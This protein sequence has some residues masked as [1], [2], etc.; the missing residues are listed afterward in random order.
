MSWQKRA[1]PSRPQ[2]VDVL[3]HLRESLQ[4]QWRR[5]RKRL[6]RCQQHFSEDAVHASRVETRRLLSILELIGAFVPESDLRKVRRDLK[7]HL[8]TFDQ[9]RD[10]QVQL[11]YV[12]RMA[13]SFPDAWPF[14]EWLRERKVRFTRKT[15][16]AVK[17]IKIRR[18]G[19]HRAAL[20]REIRRQ[21]KQITREQAF[22]VVERAIHQAF[23]QVAQ[24]CR[25]VRATDTRTIH[26]TRIAF[27]RFRYMVEA[28]AP[29]LPAVTQEHH[30]AMRGYQCMM[31]D[32]QDMEVLLAALDK[33]VQ[34][35]AVDLASA[36]RLKRELARWRE[37]LIQV[38][39]NAADR[40]QRFWPPPDPGSKNGPKES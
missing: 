23:A 13:G 27:K 3:Q 10:T 15:R 16:K 32:I 9:L 34:K 5:Y 30:R 12:E 20:E 4:T 18:L 39:L 21:R 28:M 6:K 33:F 1:D 36:R 14:H 25:R 29:L 17:Q 11:T 26:R 40:L 7:R 35:E 19:R 2:S 38:Y 31:G 37:M 24:L 8:N 22:Q